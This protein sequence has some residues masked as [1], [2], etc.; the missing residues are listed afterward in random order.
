MG[1]PPKGRADHLDL[2]SWNIACA[3]CGR[4]RKNTDVRRLPPGVPGAG[5]YVCYP[6][7]W[8]ARHPQEFVRGIPDRPAAPF[9][10]LQTDEFLPVCDLLGISSV[11]DYAVADCSICDMPY[12]GEDPD[13][14][15]DAL[16]LTTD[17]DEVLLTDDGLEEIE[18]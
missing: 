17:D 14:L 15:P 13:T 12:L 11:S 5:L 2:G 18:E 10:Q 9:V 16:L 7:H 8:N 6:E 1:Q 3:E 4:K